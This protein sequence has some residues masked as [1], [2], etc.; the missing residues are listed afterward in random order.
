MAMLPGKKA[1]PQRPIDY[2]AIWAC[3]EMSPRLQ[4]LRKEWEEAPAVIVA[5]DAVNFTPWLYG[6]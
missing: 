5:D 3:G 6:R 1:Y 2:D 4:K